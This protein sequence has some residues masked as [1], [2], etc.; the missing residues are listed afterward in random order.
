MAKGVKMAKEAFKQDFR[1]EN[2]GLHLL[3]V[4]WGVTHLQ[5]IRECLE[6][7]ASF[8][9]GNLL[10]AMNALDREQVKLIRENAAYAD[11]AEI[12]E[13]LEPKSE[14]EEWY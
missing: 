11:A 3:Y 8:S 6:K 7:L 14:P 10:D 2:P 1:K 9:N 5:A 4:K 13:S 12:L